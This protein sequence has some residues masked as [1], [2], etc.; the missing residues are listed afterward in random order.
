MVAVV[1]IQM[2]HIQKLSLKGLVSRALKALRFQNYHRKLHV[3]FVIYSDFETL[4]N[5]ISTTL[6]NPTQL[7]TTCEHCAVV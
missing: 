7:I 3:P 6:P 2:Y 1:Y 4:V 5:P